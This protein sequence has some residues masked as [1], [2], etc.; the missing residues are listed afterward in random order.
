MH[1]SHDY[2][3]SLILS[4]SSEVVLC[5]GRKRRTSAKRY[6]GQRWR[7]TIRPPTFLI[8]STGR[9]ILNLFSFLLIIII[10]LSYPFIWL[11]YF[12]GA[13][14]RGL[15]GRWDSVRGPIIFILLSFQFEFLTP[16]PPSFRLGRN[17]ILLI[18]RGH[19]STGGVF[20]C[21]M[22]GGRARRPGDVWPPSFCL[23]LSLPRVTRYVALVISFLNPFLFELLI[24]FPTSFRRRQ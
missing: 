1:I 16:F 20:L 15:V 10:L 24:P 17:L 6:F 19:T 13:G 21:E 8:R 4:L 11:F 22:F 23:G 9:E 3:L 2:F 12:V 5:R 14:S 7:G 18:G